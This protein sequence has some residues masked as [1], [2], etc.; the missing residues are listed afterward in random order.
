MYKREQAANFLQSVAPAEK[1]ATTDVPAVG[2]Y[3]NLLQLLQG[4]DVVSSGTAASDIDKNE[5][6]EPL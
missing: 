2:N 1:L 6:R 3:S 5:A 4:R